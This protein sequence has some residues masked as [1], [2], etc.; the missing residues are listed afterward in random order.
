MGAFHD[1]V[2]VN[3]KLQFHPALAWKLNGFTVQQSSTEM[4]NGAWGDVPV[5]LL[6][7]PPAQLNCRALLQHRAG[8][9]S[10]ANSPTDHIG[11]NGWISCMD[12]SCTPAGMWHPT[13]KFSVRSA[14]GFWRKSSLG[15]GLATGA[16]K[17]RE[18]KH[19][20]RNHKQM[21]N[22]KKGKMKRRLFQSEEKLKFFLQHL[23]HPMA[24]MVS[25]TLLHLMAL[26]CVTLKHLSQA[27]S[28]IKAFSI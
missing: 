21:E 11:T 27:K 19:A 8:A 2:N 7:A 23:R 22:I 13:N 9:Q 10:T 15:K 1:R 16:W 28:N 26:R 17:G 18:E 24:V 4:G 25:N 12:N 6:W 20:V 14:N 3:Y 5:V